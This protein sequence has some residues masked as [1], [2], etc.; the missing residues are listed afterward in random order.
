MYFNFFLLDWRTQTNEP[1][2]GQG[3][4]HCMYAVGTTGQ[5][6]DGPC[7]GTVGSLLCE[8]DIMIVSSAAPTR[9]NIDIGTESPGKL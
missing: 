2:N 6:N 1:N 9:E 8:Q 7:Y 4:E 3:D 5:W